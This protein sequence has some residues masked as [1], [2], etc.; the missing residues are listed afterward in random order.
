[1][2][3]RVLVI[4]EEHLATLLGEWAQRYEESPEE[5]YEKYEAK[6]Y[7]PVAAEYVFEL[8]KEMGY[9]SY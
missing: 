7:G 2:T 6:E 8:A 5:F 4:K 9:V 3:E 1:M